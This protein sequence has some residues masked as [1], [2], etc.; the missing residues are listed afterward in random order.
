MRETEEDVRVL[1]SAINEARNKIKQLADGSEKLAENYALKS[2]VGIESDKTHNA[3][4]A[5]ELYQR[6]C[7][8]REVLKYLPG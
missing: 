1:Q 6:A 4:T 2:I 5:K 7:T 8:I 3:T